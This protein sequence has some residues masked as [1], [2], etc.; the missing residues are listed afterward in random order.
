MAGMYHQTRLATVIAAVEERLARVRVSP[1]SDNLIPLLEVT[2]AVVRGCLDAARGVLALAKAPE[3]GGIVAAER[4]AWEMWNELKF[5]LRAEDPP[6]EAVKVQVNALIDV[7][8]LLETVTTAPEG[9]LDRNRDGLAQFERK[10]PALVEKVC[11]QRK[12]R[13]MHWSGRSRT[14]V[15]GP[16]AASKAVY[17]ML[18]WDTHPDIV[19]IRDIAA[20]IRDG[21]GT[22]DFGESRDVPELVER[23]CSSASESLLRSWNLFAEFWQQDQVTDVAPRKPA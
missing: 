22:L 15:V 13:K 9:M 23:P 20:T 17:K 3:W 5:L 18:S 8:G 21:V 10:Y 1:M 12:D 6:N 16:D 19:S 11:K 2:A 7:I 4:S 14:A